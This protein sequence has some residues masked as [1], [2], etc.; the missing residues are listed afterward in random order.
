MI[1]LYDD[2]EE[3]VEYHPQ[4]DIRTQEIP[5]L[6]DGVI[7]AIEEMIEVEDWYLAKTR[8]EDEERQFDLEPKG[9]AHRS[10]KIHHL[11]F[12]DHNDPSKVVDIAYEIE[13]GKDRK[14]RKEHDVPL[15]LAASILSDPDLLRRYD[16]VH[17]QKEDRW[18]VLGRVN[19]KQGRYLFLV[20]AQC[21]YTD[22]GL[23]YQMISARKALPEE[24]ELYDYFR[25]VR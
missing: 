21:L 14:N 4:Q 20:Y 17:S 8:H 10:D 12:R 7:E 6:D 23:V 1:S 18:N 2:E 13:E 22:E 9:R 3:K 15:K 24:E 25:Y 16:D 5:T 19:T 11:R